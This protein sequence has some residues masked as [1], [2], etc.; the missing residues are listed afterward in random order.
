MCPARIKLVQR[1]RVG[2]QRLRIKQAASAKLSAEKLAQA[3]QAAA[4]AD[5]KAA[6]PGGAVPVQ[7]GEGTFGRGPDGSSARAGSLPPPG[8]V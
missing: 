1:F 6:Q 2:K 3:A 8:G 4:K 5:A 7:S